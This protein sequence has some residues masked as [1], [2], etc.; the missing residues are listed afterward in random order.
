MHP[1]IYPQLNMA[2]INNT[3]IP[4]SNATNATAASNEHDYKYGFQSVTVPV[5]IMAASVTL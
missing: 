1:A 4:V 2:N 5:K 3:A